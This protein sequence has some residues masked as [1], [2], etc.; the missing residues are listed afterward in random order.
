MTLEV[1]E[2]IGYQ[3]YQ[4]QIGHKQMST[5]SLKPLKIGYRY[6]ANFSQTKDGSLIINSLKLKPPLLQKELNFLEIDSWEIIDNFAKN[7]I[8]FFKN[9]IL[10]LLLNTE[11][12]TQFLMLTSMLLALNENIIHLPFKI[13]KRPFLLQ[14]RINEDNLNKN[15]IDFYFAFDTLG[16]IKGKIDKEINMKVLY[17]KSLILLKEKTYKDKILNIT[18]SEDMLFPLWK[19]DDG[20]LDVKG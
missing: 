10:N 7:D 20:L 18:I 19:G 1:L 11:N 5:R 3:R 13:D 4:L 15:V 12:R 14:W 9:W 17:E 16:A 2:Q 6:W 8:K